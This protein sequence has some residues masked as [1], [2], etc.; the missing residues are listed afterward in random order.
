MTK[1]KLA[2][3]TLWFLSAICL[4]NRQARAVDITLM[5][6]PAE[7]ARNVYE[8]LADQFN[9]QNADVHFRIIWSDISQKMQLLAAASA[10]PD[11]VSLP[12]F[13]LIQYHHELIDLDE[14]AASDPQTQSQIYP[15]ILQE[16]RY[17][18]RLKMMPIFFNVPLLYYRPDLFRDAGISPPDNT[19]TWA[20]YRA[21]AKKLTRR[22]AS[23]SVQVWGTSLECGWWVEWLGFI[24][25]AGGDLMDDSGRLRIGEPATVTGLSFLHS[26]IHEDHSA[27]LPS[28]TPAGGF[29]SGRFAMYYGGHVLEWLTLRKSASFEWDIAPLPAG[30]A[31]R[32][33]G[34]FAVAGFGIWRGCKNPQAAW[35][36]L[37]FLISK[38]AGDQMCEAG[39]PPVR[40]D[41]AQSTFLHFDQSLNNPRPNAPL[42]RQALIDTLSF[43]RS[44]PKH[45]DFV[46]LALGYAGPIVQSVLADPDPARLAHVNDVLERNC[47]GYAQTIAKKET[48]SKGWFVLEIVILIAASIVAV[49]LFNPRRARRSLPQHSRG[50]EKY[51]FAFISPWI[52]GLSS[53]VV[54]PLIISFYWSHTDYNIVDPPRF[55]GWSQYRSLLTQDPYFWHSL[56][57]TFLYAFLAV[58]A[59]LGVALLTALLLNSKA[60]GIGLFRTLFY[61]PSILPVAASGIMWAFFLNPRWG[62]INRALALMGI[63]GPGWLYDPK[64]ALPSL[65]IVGL[66]GFGAPMIIFLAGLKGIPDSLYE[67]ASIDGAG[68]LQRFFRITLPS[69][70]PVIFFNLTMGIIAALQI[71]DVA[72]VVGSAGPGIGEPQK[73]TYFYVLNLFDKAF[74]QLNV[75]LGSAMA[76]ILFAITLTLTAVNLKA[77]R[78]WVFS[79]TAA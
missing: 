26:L 59:S 31:G 23:G 44:T 4:I 75:G 46:P 76:W 57:I 54:G 38:N 25:Q 50:S 49:R 18:G 12:H 27:P 66:W 34:D 9:H 22:D 33:T 42:H 74:I 51:F 43:A 63:K 16:C 62:I 64:W 58:P 24:R 19:W 52:V 1:Q 29:M 39:L 11:L 47:S 45:P 20:D 37:D 55:V 41:V 32:A 28:E 56:R 13:Q 36:V 35:R 71:F 61:L 78:F 15:Q 40:R 68:T 17:V 79:E 7:P 60:R 77:K 69:L 65:V 67:A 53:L 30:P 14:M 70:S 21:A 72:Y 8:R 6:S 3:V 2:A 73:S 48:A 5:L 10:L